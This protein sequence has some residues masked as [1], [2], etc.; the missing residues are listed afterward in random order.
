MRYLTLGF[1]GDP[2][3]PTSPFIRENFGQWN[4]ARGW[5][6]CTAETYG[7][8]WNRAEP[9]RNRLRNRPW[10][11]H[12]RLRL[13]R[14]VMNLFVSSVL[15]SVSFHTYPPI[16]L[17]HSSFRWP[18]LSLARSLSQTQISSDLSLSLSLSLAR[19]R[20]LSLSL[21]LLLWGERGGVGGQAGLRRGRLGDFR[22]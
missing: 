6:F 8:A 14:Q 4:R 22:V 13:L 11:P 5:S 2:A 3:Q 1:W 9:P 7:T 17:F 18:S 15:S 10:K 21:S 19:S 20:S 16:F 12:L